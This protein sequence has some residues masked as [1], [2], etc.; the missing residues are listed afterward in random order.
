M[1]KRDTFW[2]HWST[3]FMIPSD[4]KRSAWRNHIEKI[5]VFVWGVSSFV[6]NPLLFICHISLKMFSRSTFS[7][8]QR[9]CWL[10]CTTISRV[11][12]L[13]LYTIY[14]RLLFNVGSKTFYK[15]YVWSSAMQCYNSFLFVFPSC[16]P[17][18]HVR[19]T[20]ARRE[21]RPDSLFQGHFWSERLWSV[22]RHPYF[23]CSWT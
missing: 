9:P 14:H 11:R 6:L 13:P 18:F 1:Q 20:R 7:I 17:S 10:I 2:S 5:L 19:L 23:W 3:R 21:C 22:F 15:E 8:Y 4:E 16:S 12:C